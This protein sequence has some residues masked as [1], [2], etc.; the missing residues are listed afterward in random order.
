MASIEFR[1]RSTN[2]DELVAVI[3]TPGPLSLKKELPPLDEHMRK[4]IRHSPFLVMCTSD[5]A[6]NCDA[7]PRGD[8]P[9]FVRVLDDGTLLIPDRSGNKRVDGMRNIL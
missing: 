6:G 3:G 9:G 8:P 5:A 2:V 1:E 4:F 7:S